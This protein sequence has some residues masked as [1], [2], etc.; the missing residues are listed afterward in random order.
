MSEEVKV[1]TDACN[2]DNNLVD[3]DILLN[4]AISFTTTYANAHDFKAYNENSVCETKP[5]KEISVNLVKEK[6]DTILYCC[7]SVNEFVV[8][9]NNLKRELDDFA[10]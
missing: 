3:R 4:D 8:L 7:S 9:L 10:H 1:F 5:D 2:G 6:I